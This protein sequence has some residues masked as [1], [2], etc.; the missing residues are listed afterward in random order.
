MARSVWQF[1]GV[2]TEIE[3]LVIAGDY[4]RACEL[5]QA[6]LCAHDG[7]P[8][9]LLFREL[10]MHHLEDHAGLAVR[11]ALATDRDGLVMHDDIRGW[12]F[13]TPLGDRPSES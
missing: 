8:D 11:E 1:R 6:H 13:I 12:L 7:D 3:T 4:D 2:G 9:S 5:F 10:K